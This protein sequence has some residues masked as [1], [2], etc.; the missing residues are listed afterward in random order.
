MSMA[1][2]PHIYWNTFQFRAG[3]QEVLPL[4]ID[5]FSFYGSVG[6]TDMVGV[7]VRNISSFNPTKIVFP[8]SG[9]N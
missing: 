1:E 8:G 2:Q 6:D 5:C 4:F 3:H 7:I 9:M